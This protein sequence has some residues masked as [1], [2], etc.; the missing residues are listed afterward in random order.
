MERK[1]FT[2]EHTES[3]ETEEDGTEMKQCRFEGKDR[4]CSNGHVGSV[5]SA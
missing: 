2:T 3:A 4:R 5:P 1:A